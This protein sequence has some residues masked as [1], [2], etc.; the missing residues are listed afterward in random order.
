MHTLRRAMIVAGQPQER[1]LLCLGKLCS[2]KDSSKRLTQSQPY[3]SNHFDIAFF[4]QYHTQ[5]PS[6]H[7][8]I[9]PRQ[10]SRIPAQLGSVEV[11]L[12]VQLDVVSRFATNKLGEHRDIHLYTDYGATLC[13]H[14]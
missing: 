12:A 3:A 10:I 9:F 13:K 7:T 4:S 8:T 1:A 11:T 2:S 6:S 14:H 5:A